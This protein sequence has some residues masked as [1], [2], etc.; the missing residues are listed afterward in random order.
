MPLDAQKGVSGFGKGVGFPEK[1]EPCGM[2]PAIAG[3][4]TCSEGMH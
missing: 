4:N 1:T 3:S 2:H